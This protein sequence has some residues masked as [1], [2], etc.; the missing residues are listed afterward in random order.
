MITTCFNT[1]CQFSEF[2][3]VHTCAALVDLEKKY[4]VSLNIYFLNIGRDI[5]ENEPSE[6][7]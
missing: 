3:A 1:I 5:A 4:K 2:R 7:F 6:M